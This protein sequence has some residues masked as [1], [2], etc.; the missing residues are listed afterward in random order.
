[1]L[2]GPRQRDGRGETIA[3]VDAYDAPNF[4]SDLRLFDQ[5]YGLPDP[6]SFGK[7]N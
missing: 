2:I 6:P 3:V 4:A 7:V 1:V 5:Q